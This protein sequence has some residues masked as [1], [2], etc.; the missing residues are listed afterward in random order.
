MVKGVRHIIK[1]PFLL[2]VYL[3]PYAVYGLLDT[4]FAPD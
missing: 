4:P 2:T 1:R 3:V